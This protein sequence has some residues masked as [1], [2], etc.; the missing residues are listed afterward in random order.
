MKKRVISIVLAALILLLT[1]G[2]I[3]LSCSIFGSASLHIKADSLMHIVVVAM[4][5]AIFALLIFLV[6]LRNNNST[7]GF[8]HTDPLTGL[9]NKSLIRTSFENTKSLR[10][11]YF[12]LA[13][14][15][16]DS[17][18][19]KHKTV[20]AVLS[21]S[22]QKGVADILLAVCDDYDC[23]ARIENGVFMLL[24]GCRNGIA[25]QERITEITNNINLYVH[26]ELK[27]EFVPF[28]AGI[29]LP[30]K[31]STFESALAQ[32]KLAYTHAVD[33]SFN[34]YVCTEDLINKE[35]NRN[36]VREKLS[37]ALADNQFEMFVQFVYSVKQNKLVGAEALSRWR[38]PE[39]GLVM[40]GY[41]INDLRNAG[42]IK[43]FDIYMLNKVCA[44]LEAWNSGEFKDLMLSCNIT[45]V[46]V[47]S[48]DFAKSVAATLKKYSFNHNRLIL[49]ITEDALFENEIIAHNNVVQCKQMG[50]T[51]AIDDFGAGHSSLSDISDYP[52]DQIKVD[53]RIVVKSETQR[54][55]SLLQGVINFA[56][57]LGIA[58]VCEGVE[59]EQQKDVVISSGCDYIQGYYFSYVFPVEE[60][61][62]HYAESLK[63]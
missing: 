25:A 32:A 14:I 2:V 42:L 55:S 11:K 45:R 20:S 52:V 47:S 60:G 53:R 18:A 3:L 27:E 6:R 59:T 28:R 36:R 24:L 30:N 38:D 61:N 40:P 7:I 48:P 16:V 37:R 34:T 19:D 8:V 41:Y 49:E 5:L 12:C 31:N 58:V 23:A 13:Y 63:K 39:E 33:N 57:D 9:A 4:V 1:A 50:V 51:I 43:Q 26:S 35:A 15:A 56:H 17:G 46:T 29:Y 62:A 54:G 10:H 44:Q 21:D 22:L